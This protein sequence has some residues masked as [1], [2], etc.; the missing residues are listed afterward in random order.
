[1]PIGSAHDGGWGAWASVPVAPPLAA[2]GGR[3]RLMYDCVR[4]CELMKVVYRERKPCSLVSLTVARPS[5]GADSVSVKLRD[6]VGIPLMMT[7][8]YPG[9]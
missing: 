6:W 9:V 2:G 8:K 3:K 5:T 4:M 1:M 7:E